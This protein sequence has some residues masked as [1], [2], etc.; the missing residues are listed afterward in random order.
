MT[1][2]AVNES[3]TL[4]IVESRYEATMDGMGMQLRCLTQ[5]VGGPNEGRRNYLDFV[6]EHADEQTKQHG[7]RAFAALRRAVNVLN[8][9]DSGELHY[10]AF[11]FP[12]SIQHVELRRA[13]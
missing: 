10:K 2:N 13:A 1:R 3:R 9:K 6:L 12:F 11:Q 4:E 7:Q 8:P 5:E